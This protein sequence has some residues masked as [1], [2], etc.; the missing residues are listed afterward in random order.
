MEHDVKLAHIAKVAVHGFDQKMYKF[1][2]RKLIFFVV[3][4]NHEKQRCITPINNLIVPVLNKGTLVL[5]AGEAFT[6][7]FAFKGAP[8]IEGE[9]FVVLSKASLT[10]LVHH[11]YE[12][13]PHF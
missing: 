6:N 7:D 9:V 1:Q 12:S 10:L 2:Y 11:E 5:V 8:L 3:N 4:S 13:D